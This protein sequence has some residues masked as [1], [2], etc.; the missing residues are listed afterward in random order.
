MEYLLTR[1]QRDRFV[2]LRREAEDKGYMEEW[3]VAERELE[4]LD[5][6]GEEQRWWE[7]ACDLLFD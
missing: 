7:E 5:A 1:T 3:A 4:R 2:Q 6:A